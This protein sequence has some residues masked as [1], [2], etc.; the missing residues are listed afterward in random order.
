MGLVEEANPHLL[1]LHFC[2]KVAGGGLH[3]LTVIPDPTNP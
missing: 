3:S 2:A 1:S